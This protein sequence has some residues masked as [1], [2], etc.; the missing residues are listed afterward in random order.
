MKTYKVVYSIA[1]QPG[2]KVAF[3]EDVCEDFVRI[4]AR[5]EL[6]GWNVV[7][8]WEVKEVNI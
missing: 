6:G 3:Y 2:K 8:I 1:N 5:D 7:T 4:K